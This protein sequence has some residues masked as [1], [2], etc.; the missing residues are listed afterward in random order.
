M[1]EFQMHVL[2]EPLLGPECRSSIPPEAC[3]LA[4]HV[5]INRELFNKI[6]PYCLSLR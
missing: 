5:S 6:R 4:V 1:S 3:G 2:A